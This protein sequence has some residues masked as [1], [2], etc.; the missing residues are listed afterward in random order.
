MQNIFHTVF[1]SSQRLPVPEN[2]NRPAIFISWVDPSKKCTPLI[3]NVMCIML[4]HSIGRWHQEKYMWNASIE[5]SLI[6]FGYCLEIS[7]SLYQ[8]VI[9]YPNSMSIV[10][11]WGPKWELILR[12]G[13]GV[14]TNIKTKKELTNIS[15]M[16]VIYCVL[17]HLSSNGLKPMKDTK[18]W[19]K[20][21]CTSTHT[22]YQQVLN[23]FNWKHKLFKRLNCLNCSVLKKMSSVFK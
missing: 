2:V 23:Y 9:S 12:G 5:M 3:T 17:V 14:N 20:K 1:R 21:V 8:W 18:F 11:V 7:K 19:P 22:Y 13:G 6:W 4:M 16:I 15:R 10:R